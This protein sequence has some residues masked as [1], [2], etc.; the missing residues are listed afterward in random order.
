[1]AGIESKSERAY[2][3]ISEKIA[4]GVYAPGTALVERLLCEELDVSRSPVRTALTRL[5]NEGELV[6]KTAGGGMRVSVLSA[7]DVGELIDLKNVLDSA[8]LER[9]IARASEEELEGLAKLG[10]GAVRSCE[11]GDTEGVVKNI[12]LFHRY[13]VGRCG[14]SRLEKLTAAVLAPLE[15]LLSDAV[16]AAGACGE[17]AGIYGRISAAAAAR[18]ARSACEYER[19]GAELIRRAYLLRYKNGA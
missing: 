4:S 5:A 12:L 8:A 10:G 7:R 14:N 9:F 3:L 11:A 17:L 18:D 6:E 15:R 19:E 1:M 16:S 2:R 13:Y